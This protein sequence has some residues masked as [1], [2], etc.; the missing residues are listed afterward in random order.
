MNVAF[1]VK[2]DGVNYFLEVESMG[3][4]FRQNA[5]ARMH[6]H[7]AYHLILV[8]QGSNRILL[9]DSEPVDAGLNSL[10]LINPMVPHCFEP[11]K[12]LGVEHTCLIWRFRDEEGNY[13]DFPLQKLFGSEDAS[14]LLMRTLSDE[15]AQLFIRKEKEMIRMLDS[16]SLPGCELTHFASI[17]KLN[18]IQRVMDNKF[19]RKVDGDRNNSILHLAGLNVNAVLWDWWLFS[20]RLTLPEFFEPVSMERLSPHERILR[21]VMHCVKGELKDPGLNVIRIAERI[22]MHPNYVNSTFKAETGM[23]IGR[24]IRMRRLELA[25]ALL[26]DSVRPLGE[27]AAICGF[28][29]QPYFTRVFKQEF[30]MTPFAFRNKNAARE[31]V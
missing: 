31:L 9:R 13:A 27:I 3:H 2:I 24:Y 11:D 30:G 16:L 12:T 6:V 1:Q 23:T 15:D 8:S 18:S 19:H 21:K 28:A 5:D 29:Q 17:W 26:C 4:S 20:L 14:P 10:T 25:V 22:G 7:P